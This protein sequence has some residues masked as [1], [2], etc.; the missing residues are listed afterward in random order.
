[1]DVVIAVVAGALVVFGVVA[2]VARYISVE[3]AK[4]ARNHDYML[5]ELETRAA[6]LARKDREIR[7]LQREI[8]RLRALLGEGG[9]GGRFGSVTLDDEPIDEPVDEFA[10]EGERPAADTGPGAAPEQSVDE[11]AERRRS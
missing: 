1:M 8:R 10:E 7:L 3:Q 2:A 6:Q 9:R 4:S 5:K 11:E